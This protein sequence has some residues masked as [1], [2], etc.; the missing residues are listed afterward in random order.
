MVRFILRCRIK[1]LYNGLETESLY[2]VDCSVPDLESL[3]LRGGIAKNGYE[4]HDVVGVEVFPP[5]AT[6]D[7]T[8]D[9]EP[10]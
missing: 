8:P 3:L 4:Y 6:G 1:D 2:T 7:A 5:R 10:R 9:R